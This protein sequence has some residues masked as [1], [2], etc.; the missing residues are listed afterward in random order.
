VVPIPGPSAALSA[1]A[2]SGLATDS[3]RFC[4][5][6]PAK[7]TQR[8]KTLEALRAESCTLIFYEAPH[9]L[10]ESL[11]DI[12]AL[13]GERPTVIAREL[14]KMHEEFVRGTPA[15]IRARLAGR[16]SLKGEITLLIGKQEE[17]AADADAAEQEVRALERQGIARIDAVKQVAKA[18]GIPKRELYRRVIS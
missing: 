10:L 7:Q 4:G 9:R 16:A 12:E 17:S 3:F 14:T 1:L 13:L 5:F 8:R 6:L 2:A 18:R 15:S 11:S